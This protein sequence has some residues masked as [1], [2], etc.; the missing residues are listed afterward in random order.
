MFTT[1]ILTNELI[2]LKN[3]NFFFV[4]LQAFL[5]MADEG[6][7]STM[8]AYYSSSGAQLR[9]R[10]VYVQFS[11]HRELKTDQTH[12]NA[13][14]S[15]TNINA[16]PTNVSIIILFYFSF[17]IYFFNPLLMYEDVKNREMHLVTVKGFLWM[18]YFLNR[19][20]MFVS[21][22]VFAL[23]P[24]ILFAIIFMKIQ[25]KRFKVRFC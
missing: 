22:N 13:V 12:S 25:L 2:I 11:N 16:N 24:I 4:W 5:E 20:N 8:V 18:I 6:A 10:A 17:L 7:A 19:K 1:I 21:A 23:F 15:P 14:S 9:N 3:T